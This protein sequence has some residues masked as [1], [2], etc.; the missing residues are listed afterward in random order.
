MFG[1]LTRH[2]EVE[3]ITDPHEWPEAPRLLEDVYSAMD[4][5]VFGTYSSP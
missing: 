2:L 3:Q 1:Y 4:A 5:V